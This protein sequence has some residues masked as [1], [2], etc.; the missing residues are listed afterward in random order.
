ML[1]SCLQAAQEATA[2]DVSTCAQTKGAVLQCLATVCDPDVQLSTVCQADD[3]HTK[4]RYNPTD[5]N[6]TVGAVD[7]SIEHHTDTWTCLYTW[8]KKAVQGK[9]A[10]V[11]LLSNM[12]TA[13]YRCSHSKDGLLQAV[14]LQHLTYHMGMPQ[15]ITTLHTRALALKLPPHAAAAAVAAAGSAGLLHC[16]QA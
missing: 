5:Q 13:G 3:K 8:G 14:H 15:T 4:S 7:T 6:R 10:T 12:I 2:I 11:A 1:T 16:C 9:E